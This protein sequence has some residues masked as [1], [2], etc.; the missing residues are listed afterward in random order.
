M[1]DITTFKRKE[2]KYLLDE[3]EYQNLKLRLSQRLTADEHGKSEICNIY[4]DTPDF[5]LIRRSL[6]KPVYKEKLRVRSYGVPKE[7]DRVFVELKKKYKGIV[8]KRR[9]ALALQQAE[10]YLKGG[11]AAPKNTQ[12]MR[13]IGWFLSY[14]NDL[15]P[16]MGICYD[17]E[18][19]YS[20]EDSSVR[21]TFDDNIRWRSDRLSLAD[22]AF[23]RQLLAPGQHLM[24]LKVGGAMPLWLTGL[25]DE[26]EIYPV[27]FSK[28][29]KAYTEKC[30][31]KNTVLLP[32]ADKRRIAKA[33]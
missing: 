1:S 6:E 15:I 10:T 26:L 31:Q 19:Y 2:I 20:V 25:L 33:V 22:G 9:E 28:Y 21:I 29:G 30:R 14:Y 23:G 8:Y 5:E 4:Y 3:E 7:N 13:E 12:I 16:V 32:A 27:S 11:I 24:E 17:R 18:A